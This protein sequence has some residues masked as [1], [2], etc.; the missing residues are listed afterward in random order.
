M[1]AYA[2]DQR[3]EE[4]GQFKGGIDAAIVVRISRV[5]EDIR[6]TGTDVAGAATSRRM[7]QV[8]ERTITI[9]A[10]TL[11]KTMAMTYSRATG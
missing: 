3:H 10:S 7:Y 1:L 2:T 4:S 8:G 11:E 5:L 6:D 9:A